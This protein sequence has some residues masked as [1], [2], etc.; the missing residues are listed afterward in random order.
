M[1]DTKRRSGSSRSK[2]SDAARVVERARAQ[3]AALTGREVEGVLGIAPD[4]NGGGWQ[5]TVEVV[6]LHRVPNSTDV[7]GYYVA[8]LDDDGELLGYERR[9]R[10]QRGQPDEDVR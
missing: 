8:R 6:E 4:E 1:A 7:M 3:L 5:V 10:Y 9:R 2:G